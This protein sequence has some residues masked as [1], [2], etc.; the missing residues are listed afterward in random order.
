MSRRNGI[1]RASVTV[2]ALVIAACSRVVDAPAPQ[3]NRGILD[4]TVS[5]LTDTADGSRLDTVAV[6]VDTSFRAFN[7]P[8]S[9]STT[10]GALVNAASSGALSALADSLGVARAYLRAPS[11][12]SVAVITASAGGSIASRSIQFVP[13]PPSL[14]R[15]TASSY[16]V[17]A[18]PG[19]MVTIT[20]TVNRVRGAISPG[21]VVRF[22]I[23]PGDSAV[24]AK[25]SVDSA[26]VSGGTAATVA[27]LQ[28]AT[29]GK[30]DVHATVSRSGVVLQGDVVLEIIPKP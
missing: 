11:D 27:V 2:A 30:L 9:F 25:L 28:Q 1:L 22:E 16:F 29:P 7:S 12:S 15:V 5:A 18:V 26:F 8:V 10:A 24:A 17:Q 21:A 4:M 20:A 3:G 19:T 13:A 6:R 23:V 14:L